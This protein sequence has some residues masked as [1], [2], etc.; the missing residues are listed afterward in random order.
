MP[1]WALAWRF[2]AEREKDPLTGMVW[3]NAAAILARPWPIN[4][5]F[6]SQGRLVWIAIT[7]QLDIASMKLIKAITNAAGSS[8]LVVS[9]LS[10]GALNCGN[11]CGTAP[12]TRPPRPANPIA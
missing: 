6:S 1:L 12:T 8:C 9:Q 4:S 10:V 2:N 11:P 3:L 7:L 5:W